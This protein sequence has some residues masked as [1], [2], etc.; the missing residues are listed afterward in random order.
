MKIQP[1]RAGGRAGAIRIST[2]LP[3]IAKSQAVW[4]LPFWW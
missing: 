2:L 1:P 4:P 3:A